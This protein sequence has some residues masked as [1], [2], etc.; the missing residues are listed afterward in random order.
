MG[1][2]CFRLQGGS[3]NKKL[4]KRGETKSMKKIGEFNR[5]EKRR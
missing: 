1:K 4:D 3:E 5:K 2:I